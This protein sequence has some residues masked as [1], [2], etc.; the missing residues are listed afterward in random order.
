VG[1]G[2]LPQ[3][4][5]T[6]TPANGHRPLYVEFTDKSTGNISAW[7]WDFNGDGAIDS[8]MQNANYT[9]ETPGNY[10]VILTVSG[11]NGNDTEVKKKYIQ[12]TRQANFIA[13]PANGYPPLDVEFTDKSTG[14]ISAWEW[15]FNG[16]GRIDSIMQEGNYTYETPGNY[17]V[18]LTVRGPNGNDTEVKKDYIQVTRCP[19]LAD[20]IID[21]IPSNCQIQGNSTSCTGTTTVHFVDKSTGNVTGWAWDFE[22]DGVI[23]STEQNPTHVY[24]RNG[25]YAVALTITTSECK[26]TVTKFDYINLKSCG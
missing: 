19:H 8:I 23:D 20:F 17:T 21:P 11:P 22:S 2:N 15:D 12:V 3:A 24:S 4:N 18:S 14:N 5:F 16:D 10:T 7:E 1:C 6:A 9:Y 26:D 25:K 13:I